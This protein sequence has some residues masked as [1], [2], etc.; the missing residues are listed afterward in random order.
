MLI[1][2]RVPL[3]EWL[4]DQSDFM[5]PGLGGAKN[6]IPLSQSY[7][8]LNGLQP[9]S[10]AVDAS[11]PVVG[12][13]WFRDE[14]NTIV[15]LAGTVDDLYQI[16][17]DG[18]W[19]SV[20]KSG[21]YSS[22]TNWEFARF[23]FNVIAVA[24]GVTPQVMDLSVSSPAFNDL[25]GSPS[26]PQSAARVAIIQDHVFLGDLGTSG[27][28]HIQWSG[29]N[30][31]NSWGVSRT[32]QADIQPLL[33]G[34][35]VQKLVRGNPGLIFQEEAIRVIR[36]VGGAAIFAIQPLDRRRGTRAPNSVVSNGMLTWWY[37]QDGFHMTDGQT[38]QPIGAERVNRW[39]LNEVDAS[40]INEI[41][42]SVDRKNRLV[43][44]AFKTSSTLDQADRVL[45]YN[46]EVDRWAYAE[47]SV[48]FLAESRSVGYTLDGL[49][50]PLPAGIDIDSIAI[51]SDAFRG[52][53]LAFL[54]FT[55]DGRANT[56][57]GAALTAELE[58]AE[59]D[60]GASR[61][62]V[63]GV[64][65]FVQGSGETVVTVQ[66]AARNDLITP[67][68]F[69]AAQPL[70]RAGI[71]PLHVDG[72]YHRSRIV[73]DGGFSHATAVEVLFRPSGAL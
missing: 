40:S 9:F 26:N 68:T 54:A 71:A 5:N 22:V 56:F 18:T 45:L 35:K 23:G 29:Y 46:Y 60:T 64:R 21:G 41:Q 1:P 19:S 31:L 61:H 69:S 11:N 2:R 13:A 70:N 24:E 43:M 4:P 42:G 73:V 51:E 3:G 16:Q 55:A 58:T 20:G 33:E 14:A 17:G 49:D 59:V 37:A 6:C 8:S 57:D 62:F 72:R 25:T 39:F 7:R 34:G 12:A 10:G 27:P 48:A 30:R 44:W 32:T 36:K 53:A 50:T 28:D 52:G 67:P 15:V 63:G 65:P 38:V 47:L 66:H